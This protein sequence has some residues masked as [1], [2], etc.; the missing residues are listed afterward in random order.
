MLIAREHAEL[1]PIDFSSGSV[2]T[3]GNFDG[4]HRGHQ[5]L[6]SRIT[7]R[8]QA[9]GHKS[10]VVTF[11]PHPLRVLVGPHTPP[12][13]TVREEKLDVLE[14]LDLDLTLMLNFTKELA[15][16]E[17]RDFVKTYLV[18]WLTTRHLVVGYDYS[19]G[20]GRKGNFA[21][22]SELGQEFGFTCEQLNAVILD[23]AIVSS[24]R[25]RDLIKAGRVWDA[26]NLLGRFFVIRGTVIHG[27]NRGGRLLG[28]PTA[29]L[30]IENEVAPKTGVYAVWAQ[31]NGTAY[32]AVANIGRNP[33][34]GDVEE[35]SVEVHIL[36]F[37][38]DLYGVELRAHFVQ[39]LRDEKK[40]SGPEEL[41]ARIK[42][43]VAL[44]RQILASPEAALDVQPS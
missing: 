34:F 12:L 11:C 43:D 39:R 26:L 19:F 25:I 8:A 14:S 4:V 22:L 41:V 37:D 17:P 16:L 24:T 3:I 40:F 28:F 33:T 6:I 36:D 21:L 2:V 10:V 7:Q 23:D 31:I 18:D 32:P 44:G 13:I 30:K 29:N 27:K 9:A 42:E 5:R 20:K 38:Q 1:A 35:P 15:A